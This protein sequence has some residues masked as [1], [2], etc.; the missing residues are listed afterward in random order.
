MGKRKGS[1]KGLALINPRN[2]AKEVHMYGYHFSWRAH[3][4]W[5][6]GAVVGSVLL[7]VLFRLGAIGFFVTTLAI[8]CALPLL[9]LDMYKRM[10]E[11]KRFADVSSY[12]EQVLYSFL[13][14][15]KVVSA[16]K[17]TRE[18][19]P[20]GQ[21][22]QCLDMVILH[23]ELGKPTTSA[24]V[25]REGL[26]MLE[27][28]YPCTKISMVHKLLLVT[29]E[30]GGA[31]E[32]AAM[33]MLEDIERWKRRG[34]RLHA[35]KKKSHIDNVISVLVAVVL[36]AVAL[37]ILNVLGN[38]FATGGED[39]FSISVIQV[40]STVFILVLLGVIVKSTRN[41]TDDWLEEEEIFDTKYISKSYEL[42]KKF[43]SGKKKGKIFGYH[44]AK[45][46][47]TEAMYL[48]LP[49]WLLELMLLLQHNNV[50]VALTK[51]ADTAPYVL[52]DELELL[53]NRMKNQPEK[54]LT[55]TEFCRGYDVP[56]IASCMRM[57][58]AFSENGTGNLAMQ[59]NQLLARV[60]QMQEKADEL[61]DS[62][63]AFR[64]KLMF[65]YPVIAATGKLL[66]D[67]MVGMTVMMRM[68]GN[69]GGM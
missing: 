15:G 49:Q 27:K 52:R 12:M 11:Q 68:L 21:M 50:Q 29:E 62:Q 3:L 30:Q 5:I 36:C 69:I 56:E 31:M 44:L 46:D 51:S 66:L 9:V 26:D 60:W 10:Y 54:L 4:I 1:R 34:Y 65:S 57:L 43:E 18:L 61:R 37:Y 59:M 6:M 53:K 25:T 2:L 14:T 35:E 41:L 39:I 13:K 24:G 33:I 22:R 17:E 63:I 55:Y 23:M 19:Y 47:V 28:M 67:L 48:A 32:D 8:G 16:M 40:S 7:G 20:E 42:V 45:R 64:M 38:M 58:H